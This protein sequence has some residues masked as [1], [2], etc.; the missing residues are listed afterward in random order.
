M[1]SKKPKDA[2]GPRENP[3]EATLPKKI[4][5]YNNQNRLE[6]KSPQ[7]KKQKVQEKQD[8]EHRQNRSQN[9]KK[10]HQKLAKIEK[11]QRPSNHLKKKSKNKNMK[12]MK[13]IIKKKAVSLQSPQEV[14]GT[15]TM[16]KAV[17]GKTTQNLQA[18]MGTMLKS[19]SRTAKFRAKEDLR[20]EGKNE[21]N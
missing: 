14:K 16:T 7:I 18:K 5:I 6:K 8:Q 11:N 19:Q 9:W 3:N 12:R 4:K 13:R 20:A 10:S 17:Q 21:A 2:K 15:K 1:R